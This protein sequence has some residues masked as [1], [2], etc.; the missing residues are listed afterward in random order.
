M[1]ELNCNDRRTGTLNL[2]NRRG[3]YEENWAI[4]YFD[5]DNA[6]NAKIVKQLSYSDD[7]EN[8]ESNWRIEFGIPILTRR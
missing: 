7:A 5:F 6:D 4:S 2:S 8:L 1:Q 3:F